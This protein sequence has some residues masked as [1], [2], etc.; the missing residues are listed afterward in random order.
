MDGAEDADMGGGAGGLSQQEVGHLVQVVEAGNLAEGGVAVAG[1][2][3]G[4]GE[5]EHGSRAGQVRG[6]EKGEGGEH[7]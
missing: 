1:S 5:G 7:V 2:G 3:G 6:V 4:I